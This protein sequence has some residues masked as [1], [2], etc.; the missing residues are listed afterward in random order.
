MFGLG[1]RTTIL[2][3]AAV[4]LSLNTLD[5]S[6]AK[7]SG[8]KGSAPG[9]FRVANKTAYTVTLTWDPPVAASGDFTY[10]LWGAYNVGPT[11]VL[12]KTA[13][14]YTFTALF[15]GNSYTFGIYTKDSTGKTSDQATLS[16]IVLPLDITPP[17]TAPVVSID[18]VGANYANLSWIPARDD[19]PH[20]STQIYLNGVFYFGVGRGITN[21]TLRFL[22]P[23]TTYNLTVRAVDFCNNAGPFTAPIN[24]TTPP[25]NPADVTP[26]TTPTNLAAETFG[27]GS[28]ET[29][30]RWTGSTDDFDDP[31]NIRYDVYV[32]G[33][34]A[35][36]M[37][38]TG[39]ES[40]FYGEFGN[41]V[42]EVFATDTSGNVSDPAVT[43]L[44]IP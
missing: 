32:N 35:D 33:V 15:P 25:P 30:L 14:S 20:L 37:F 36:I 38:G 2:L 42:I 5:A 34:L 8:S 43:L 17:S 41:N 6:A 4:I 12:P 23:A 27:D 40:I 19:G 11:V 44:T 24:L 1:N 3:V 9:N 10:Q 13:T 28:T 22:E 18:E 21:A 26:P 16:G 29:H 31:I 7:R 39:R